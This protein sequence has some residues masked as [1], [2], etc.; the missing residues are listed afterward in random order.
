MPIVIRELVIR[1]RVEENDHPSRNNG[2]IS[3]D[4]K[5]QK[6]S[7]MEIERIVAMCIEKTMAVINRKN[8]R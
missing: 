8:E 1:A 7:E 6:I 5:S 4:M 3:T 2:S